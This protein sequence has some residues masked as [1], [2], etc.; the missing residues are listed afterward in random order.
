[1]R[2]ATRSLPRLRLHPARAKAFALH[3]HLDLAI[4]QAVPVRAKVVDLVRQRTDSAW[5]AH[6]CFSLF[7]ARAKVGSFAVYLGPAMELEFRRVSAADFSA[8]R[9]LPARGSICPGNLCCCPTG[10]AIAP[11]AVVVAAAGFDFD[12][13]RNCSAIEI[14]VGLGSFRRRFV[15]GSCPF[16]FAVAVAA[17]VF[18]S[19]GASTAR[20][21]FLPLPDSLSRLH[22]SDSTSK[23]IRNAT[24]RQSGPLAWSRLSGP[25]RRG[26][27]GSGRD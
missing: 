14:V 27:R 5:R 11:A 8:A 21:S 3:L 17:L 23:S 20:S 6:F 4:L 7:R 18:V 22:F 2:T 13:C 1:M 24:P 12:L 16:Y 19:D 26:L 10:F 15:A 9:F 25:C